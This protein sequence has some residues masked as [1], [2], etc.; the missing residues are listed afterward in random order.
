MLRLLT[1]IS[2][3][4]L[5][6]FATAPALAEVKVTWQRNE[7]AAVSPRFQFR[8]IPAPSQTDA[9]TNARCK[10]VGGRE[11]FNSCASGLSVCPG[12]VVRFPIKPGLKVPQIGWNQVEQTRLDCPIFQ[13]IPD[14]SHF[15]FVHSYYPRPEDDSIVA[16]RTQY[17]EPFASSV[18]KDNVFATQFHPEKSQK[19]GLKLL[20]NFVKL[21]G[22]N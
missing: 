9:A 19:F 17:G 15:Y 12:S 10:I 6:L 13:G 2:L 4:S 18:W 3:G 1:V 5:A 20:A 11:D 7:P 16:S 21:I 8:N 14:R 22:S